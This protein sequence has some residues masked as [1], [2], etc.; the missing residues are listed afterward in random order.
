MR[1]ARGRVVIGTRHRRRRSRFCAIFAPLI[2]PH[3]PGDQNLLSILLPP[4]WVAGRRSA[5]SARHRQPRPRRAVAPDLRRPHRDDGCALRLARR[6][7]HRRDAGAYRRLFRRRGRLADR[8]P[9]RRLDVVSAGDPVADPDGRARRRRSTRSS[10]PSCWS[11][12]R[13]SA[14]CCAAK[15]WW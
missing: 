15:C 10:S 8:P 4:A 6:H 14:A 5:I 1:C 2:A 7:D 12:G 11:T 3:D 13:A 9:G